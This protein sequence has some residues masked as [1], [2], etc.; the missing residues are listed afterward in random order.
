MA[1]LPHHSQ[2]ALIIQDAFAPSSAGAEPPAFAGWACARSGVL[3]VGWA[4]GEHPRRER[5]SQTNGQA[6]RKPGMGQESI[7]REQ[8]GTGGKEGKE[9]D[10]QVTR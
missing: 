10:P 7:E 8:Q 1:V 5:Y 3:C 4:H 2:F 9:G 6:G